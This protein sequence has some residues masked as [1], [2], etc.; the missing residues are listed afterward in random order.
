MIDEILE[1]KGIKYEDLKPNERQTF[2]SML[3][4]LNKSSLTLPKLKDYI[5]SM[6]DTVENELVNEPEFVRILGIFA[7]PNRNQIYLKARL[8]NYI[9]LQSFLSTPEKAKAQLENALS[10]MMVKR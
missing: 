8:R 2:L 1:K 10:G 3:D 5:T 6:R 9:L 4:Q 7:V